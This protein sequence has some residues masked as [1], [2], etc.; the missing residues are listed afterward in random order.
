MERGLPAKRR[1]VLRVLEDRQLLTKVRRP[2]HNQG[3]LKGKAQGLRLFLSRR[4][5]AM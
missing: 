4:L 5:R 2:A 3:K 1:S